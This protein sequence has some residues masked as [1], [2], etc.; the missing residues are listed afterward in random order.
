MEQVAR[1]ATALMIFLAYVTIVECLMASIV[2]LTE[3]VILR[4]RALLALVPPTMP[5]RTSVVGDLGDQGQPYRVG[6]G[7]NRLE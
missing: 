1:A 3:F 6:G 4:V 2:L 7:I 5:K